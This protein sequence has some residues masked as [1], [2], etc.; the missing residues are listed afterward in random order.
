MQE[1]GI[2]VHFKGNNTVKD[3]LVD[4]RTGTAFLTKE[5]SSIGTNVTPEM[6]NGIH[7]GK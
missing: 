7:R 2:Q 1:R 5:V 6:Y 4:P 3:L